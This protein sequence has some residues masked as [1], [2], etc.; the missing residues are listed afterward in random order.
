MRLI[1]L[2]IRA[3]C[4]SVSDGQAVASKSLDG[5]TGRG[6]LLYFTAVLRCCI[7]GVRRRLLRTPIVRHVRTAAPRA[8]SYSHRFGIRLGR[9][10]G[11]CCRGTPILRPE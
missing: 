1:G 3:P 10:R 8:A 9:P 2:L 5:A 6:Q 11:A 4:A 7:A